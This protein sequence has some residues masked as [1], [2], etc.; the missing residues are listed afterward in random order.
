MNRVLIP[1]TAASMLSI[2]SA[3]TS[4]SAFEVASIRRNLSG[5]TRSGVSYQP[6]RFVA[7]NATTKT[8]IAYAY[9]VKEFQISGGPSWLDDE[10][11]NV[12][13]KED[14]SVAESRLRLPWRQYREQLGLMVQSLLA[15][16]FK[17]RVIRQS[18]DSAI[19]ALV[20]AKDGPKLKRSAALDFHSA[21]IRGRRG[22]LIAKGLSLAQLADILSWMP[23]VGVRKVVDETGIDGTFD[24]SLRWAF[25]RTP[26]ATSPAIV[27]TGVPPD[28]A[29][30]PDVS[31]PSIFDAVQEQLGLRLQAT[32][33]PIEFLVIDHI[34]EPSD[35]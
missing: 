32:K 30:L 15:D 35:N 33:G 21:D 2:S 13:A 28:A 9:N 19:L 1:V 10:R 14:D 29:A 27:N 23:E 26:S 6:G 31:G 11:F 8:V 24:L 16:R 5:D 17:L 25:D 18:R 7:E 3:Q 12:T 20:A 22:Q 34:E 4:Q